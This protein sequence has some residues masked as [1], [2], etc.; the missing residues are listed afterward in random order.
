LYAA[1]P[2][3]SGEFNL[4]APKLRDTLKWL[5]IDGESGYAKYRS[6][7]ELPANERLCLANVAQQLDNLRSY[8]NVAAAVAAGRVKLVGMYFDIAAA[9]AYLVDPDRRALRDIAV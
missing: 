6:Y 2:T 7:A 9:K 3:A 4:N 1:R 5:A 8:P